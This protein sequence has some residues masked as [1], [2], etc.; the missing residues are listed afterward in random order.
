M[1]SPGTWD[2]K[3]PVLSE[4]AFNCSEQLQIVALEKGAERIGIESGEHEGPFH[5]R[6]LWRVA[7]VDSHE[8]DGKC[9][10]HEP[11]KHYASIS[12]DPLSN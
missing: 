8:S 7:Y 2:T 5:Y 4:I 9:C 11:Q 1:S 6:V 12:I 3:S 10:Q